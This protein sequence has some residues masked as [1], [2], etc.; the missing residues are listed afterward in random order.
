MTCTLWHWNELGL[1][2]YLFPEGTIT[3]HF[4]IE[5]QRRTCIHIYF[6]NDVAVTQD[7]Q[8]AS[9]PLVTEQKIEIICKRPSSNLG[10]M[11]ASQSNSKG[12]EAPVT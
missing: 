2:S 6:A 12:L 7:S 4:T 1:T 8:N 3:F 11:P 10:T 9:E 5:N